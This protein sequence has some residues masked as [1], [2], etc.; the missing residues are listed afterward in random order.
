MKW[1]YKIITAINKGGRV[2]K[3]IIKS[4][5]QN[6]IHVLKKTALP[7]RRILRLNQEETHTGNDRRLRQEYFE[8][9]K[10]SGLCQKC[11][12]SIAA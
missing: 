1:T 2:L 5:Y 7:K 3:M 4:D 9:H 10:Y 12:I 11:F 8:N 6:N